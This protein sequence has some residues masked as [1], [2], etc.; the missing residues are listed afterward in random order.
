MPTLGTK[1]IKRVIV[2]GQ[3]FVLLSAFTSIYWQIHGLFGERGLLPVAPML[4]CE[5]ES[6]FRCRLPLLR[7]VCNVFS[8]SPAV[9]L[10]FLALVGI[11]LSIYAIHH[12]N[13]QNILVFLALFFLYRTIYEAGG[14]FMY[15]Q[16]DA[17]LLESTVY[18]A[19]LAWFEDGPADSVAMYNIVV[20][21]LRVTFMN[22][23]TKF[24][25]K[26]PTWYNLTAMDYHFE[27]QPLP[28]PF[29]W[30]AHHFPPFFR[31]LVTLLTAYIEIILPPLF[32]IPVIQVRYF[33]F[34]CQVLLTTLN[35]FTANVGFFN[36]NIL[37]L[38][39]SL[40]DTPRVAF[41][42]SV[43]AGFVFA[44]LGYD[45]YYRLPWKFTLQQD[46][47][48]TL[49]LSITH[50]KF[51]EFLAFYI[52][53]IIMFIGILFLLVLGYS[54]I[55]GLIVPHRVKKVAH[56]AFVVV[57]SILLICYGM[58]PLLRLDEKLAA[59]T[60]E[61]PLIMQYYKSANSWGLANFYGSY[62]QMTT[63]GKPEIIIEGAHAIEGPWKEFQFS[64]KP[65]DISKRPK[66]IAP[67]QPRLDWQLTLAAEGTY[68][69]NP[70]FMSLVYHLLQNTTEV[71]NLIENYPFQNRS[72]P[73]TF[74]R[75]KL[76]MYHFTN[77]GEKHWWSRDFQEEYMPP[78][79]K[80]NEALRDYLREHRILTKSKSPFVNGPLGKTLKTGH[81]ITSRIDHLLFVVGMLT[82]V[83]VTRIHRMYS[84]H[85]VHEN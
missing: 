75:A 59:R 70:F 41:G 16:W 56:M 57:T 68:Q 4:E 85:E 9:G 18:V 7:L 80:G 21:L 48:P 79:N 62:K 63:F 17:L 40:L 54:F 10:Q 38:L 14:V 58:I 6:I 37:V 11:I 74:V 30:Y 32:L 46:S 2:Y 77:I 28:T 83:F 42:S 72:E 47:G 45:I 64:S 33:V 84:N 27:T 53:L 81:R 12:T 50:D 8:F 71:V 78:Y 25:S 3:L 51:K 5:E 49:A 73:L 61:N 34:F 66:F 65:G 29:A 24:L 20:L 69:Q 76:Y 67:H 36:F 44:R 31:Q 60:T 82:L 35:V 19:I 22:G 52:D 55:K 43:L 23:V 15:Y 13:C 26:C 39:V 1:R